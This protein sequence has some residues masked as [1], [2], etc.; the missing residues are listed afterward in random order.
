MWKALAVCVSPWESPRWVIKVPRWT[1]SQPGDSAINKDGQESHYSS[2]M[3]KIHSW[4]WNS[5][6]ADISPGWLDQ[7]FQGKSHEKW[8]QKLPHR[9]H[10]ASPCLKLTFTP[11]HIESDIILSFDSLDNHMTK[12]FLTLVWLIRILKHKVLQQFPKTCEALR[13]CLAL[14]FSSNMQLE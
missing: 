11:A 9:K 14:I 12:T 3:N 1:Q 4:V 5:N 10:T 6:P 2:S 7:N 13:V 8:L